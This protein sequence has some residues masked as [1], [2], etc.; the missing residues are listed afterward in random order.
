[1]S[2]LFSLLKI[3]PDEWPRVKW[4][5]LHSMGFGLC[6]IFIVA[7][8]NALFLT[9]FGAKG[10]PYIYMGTA[11]TIPL[12]S[13]LVS[14][15]E[16]RLS[17]RTYLKFLLLALLA[18][19]I[20]FR[21]GLEATDSR[22]LILA[23]AMFM[24]AIYVFGGIEFW[25]LAS[26][27]FDV[28]EGKRLFGLIG[29]GEVAAW[30]I[31]GAIVPVIVSHT[32]LA[33]LLWLVALGLIG[34]LFCLSLIVSRY[35]ERID[36]TEE[37]GEEPGRQ[38]QKPSTQNRKYV[39]TLFATSALLTIAYYGADNMF[40]EQLEARYDDPDAVGAFLGKFFAIGGILTLV[41]R[42]SSGTILSRFGLR[43]GLLTESLT[44]GV[45]ALA[46]VVAGFGWEVPSLVFWLV[47]LHKMVERI[48][49]DSLTRPAL[50]VLYQPLP[51]AERTRVQ[52][53]S[54][55]VVEQVAGG[56][57][58]VLLLVML[59][60]LSWG[61]AEIAA[62]LSVCLAVWVGVAV[63]AEKE[64]V[65][66]LMNAL[67]KRA[68][69]GGEVDLSDRASL[70][71][72]RQG[73][74]GRHE[75]EMLY[76]ISMLAEN[77]PAALGE[78]LPVLLQHDSPRI[79]QEALSRIEQLHIVVDEAQIRQLMIN[80]EVP[81]VRGAAAR[82]LIAISEAEAFDEVLPLMNDPAIEIR[83]EVLVGLLRS[84]GIEGIIAAGEYFIA[85]QKSLVPEERVLAAEIIGEVAIDNFY[86][87]LLLLLEDDDPAVRRAALTAAGNLN[88][89]RLWPYL[90]HNLPEAGLRSNAISSL[91]T[92]GEPVLPLLATEFE[93]QDQS[94]DIQI[95]IARTCGR[96]RQEESAFLRARIKHDDYE[97]R[98]NVLAALAGQH[99]SATGD[100]RESVI[101]V[102]RL[103]ASDC[104]S[105]FH[106]YLSL[107]AEKEFEALKKAIDF[108]FLRCRERVFCLL[109][110]LYAA[111]S[112]FRARDNLASPSL[113]NQ[114]YAVEVLD[115]LIGSDVRELTF[116]LLEP[117]SVAERSSRLESL[118]PQRAEAVSARLTKILKGEFPW[119]DPWIKVCTLAEAGN[120][121]A[122][123]LTRLIKIGLADAD[124]IVQE[125]ALWL[126][127]SFDLEQARAKARE[128]SSIDDSTV[129]RAAELIDS[130]PTETLAWMK[131]TLSL[132]GKTVLLS[133]AE[134]FA[135][136]PEKWLAEIAVMLEH[137]R[138]KSETP[139]IR[140]GDMGDSM[141]FIVHGSARV[142][143]TERT[144]VE[145]GPGSVVG[146]MAALDPE[147]RSASVTSV[148]ETDLFCIRREHL[149]EVMSDH[150]E[151]A[152]G[153][154]RVLAQRLRSVS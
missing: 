80:D 33:N 73:L 145:L 48:T 38:V 36:D 144:F 100:D 54:L 150:A 117:L 111:E 72:L 64:Y 101:D 62:V 108:E 127:S 24:E 148:T 136:T 13:F 142:H 125:T 93:R 107:G 131:E 141:F 98:H 61:A 22:W 51:A 140:Q 89:P 52:A 151:V 94:R 129:S 92:I 70:D 82:A 32:G 3:E 134:I 19:T 124:S 146:E 78:E 81:A 130:E 137:M 27:L 120:L 109:S 106:Y 119:S 55:S 118:F 147:P 121:E 65:G 71:L 123:D 68:L 30:T 59:G 63:T 58:G 37:K 86:R 126:L 96:I 113:E 14:L 116:P 60:P 102:L 114:A 45:I 91:I 104:S 95:R 76:C 67:S 128:F 75:S 103:E 85:L 17:C 10:Y 25:G 79:R 28:R 115:N 35:P 138:V 9:A 133:K 6:K 154:M 1:M 29:V 39:I 12:V 11:L 77:S 50:Q 74:V 49:L 53:K 152:H 26:R 143:D 47:M 135:R 16:S 99:Y 8:A 57:V 43:P 87:P 41:G 105:A 90:I 31:G 2:V 34:E 7:A 46:I 149:R 97:V 139:I 15:L 5:L 42:F 69:G 110:Y 44:M 132:F 83:R 56:M 153:V 66:A 20:G 122:S 40:Y 88:N 4:M 84:G 21:L 18:S 23:L 112:V